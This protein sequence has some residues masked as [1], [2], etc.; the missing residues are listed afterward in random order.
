MS[1]AYKPKNYN[2]LSPYLIV[3]NA[4]ELVDLVKKLFNAKQFRRFDRDNG[5]IAHCELQIYDTV[6]MISY[7]L[8]NYLANKIML[9]L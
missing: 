5:K 1:T 9:H 4:Q 2:S 8:E 6:I 7:S 3:D